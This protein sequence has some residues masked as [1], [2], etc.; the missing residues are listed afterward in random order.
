VHIA[1]DEESIAEIEREKRLIGGLASEP[2]TA[3]P[4]D[5]TP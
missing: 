3:K 5:D 4:D 2:L 1:H